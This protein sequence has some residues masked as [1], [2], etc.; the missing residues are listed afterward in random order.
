LLAIRDANIDPLRRR[1]SE[2]PKGLYSLLEATLSRDP[3]KRPAAADELA[4]GLTP[5]EEMPLPELRA[6]LGEWVEWARDPARLAERIEGRVRESFAR[7]QATRA[8]VISDQ[9]SDDPPTSKQPPRSTSAGSHV[10]RK[11]GDVFESLPFSRIIEMIATGELE[12]DDE[13]ALLGERYRHVEDIEELAR[14]LLPSTTTTT[15]ILFGPGVPDYAAQLDETPMLE[16]LARLREKSETGALFIE[17]VTT[18]GPSSIRKEIYLSAGRLHHVASSAR[19]ELLGEYLV[20]RGRITRAQLESALAELGNY[21][22]RLGDTLVAMRLVEVM[23]LFRALRDQGRD[24]VGQLCAWKQGRVAFYRGSEPGAVQFPLDLDLASAMMSGAILA[25][26]GR[27][28]AM[29]PKSWARLVAGPRAAAAND[30]RERGT[31]PSSLQLVPSLIASATTLDDAV[32]M[33]TSAK[34]GGRSVNEREAKAALVV[35]MA[36]GWIAFAT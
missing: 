2:L 35:A 5:F 28:D 22:G 12:G 10:R 14:H 18:G 25:G 15:G 8:V 16:I 33:L 36:L 13:V 20:R 4:F 27:F 11:N 23:D 19:E 17:Q 7:M 6:T 24:R 3:N 31:A 9:T 32:D 30:K 26:E 34:M 29:L 21:G 1:A